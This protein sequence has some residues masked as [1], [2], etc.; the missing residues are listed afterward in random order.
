MDADTLGR[1]ARGE[2]HDGSAGGGI[3]LANISQRLDN[4]FADQYRLDIR[5]RPG[6]GTTV[7]LRVPLR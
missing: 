7:E 6:G 2:A 5:S 1:V 3:G 4:L